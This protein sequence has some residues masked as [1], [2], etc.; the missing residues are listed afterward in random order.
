M[1]DELQADQ[2]PPELWNCYRSTTS[3]I[4]QKLVEQDHQFIKQLV[5]LWD[6]ASSLERKCLEILCALAI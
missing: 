6:L 5:N 1:I 3:T 4:L 2:S